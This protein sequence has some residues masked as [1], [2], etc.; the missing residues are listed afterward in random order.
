MR[1][2]SVSNIK[3]ALVWTIFGVIATAALFPYILA[4][5][6]IRF[7]KV[8]V[9]LFVMI[10]A[11]LVQATILIFVLCWVGLICGT[12]IGL[13]SPVV[14]SWLDSGK[15]VINPRR[16]TIVALLGCVVALLLLAAS[17]ACDP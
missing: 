11:Q 5:F 7:A 16:V 6:P 15:F 10:G 1:S 9:P 8:P 2:L 12:S 17:W 13:D 14:R 4:L 3:V